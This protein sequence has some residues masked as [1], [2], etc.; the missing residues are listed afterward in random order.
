VIAA[1]GLQHPFVNDTV[2]LKASNQK[3]ELPCGQDKGMIGD[4]KLDVDIESV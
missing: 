3:T 4:K 2:N 1:I